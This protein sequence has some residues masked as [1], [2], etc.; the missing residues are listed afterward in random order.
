MDY[1]QFSELR[2]MDSEELY[3]HGIVG[4]KWGVRRY[5]NKDG[6]LTEAGKK[7]KAKLEKKLNKLEPK[8]VSKTEPAPKKPSVSDLSNEEL[9]TRTDRLTLEKNYMDA[10]YNR[11]A[12]ASKLNPP[13]ENKAKKLMAKVANKIVDDIILP[14][15]VALGK[16]YLNKYTKKH[17]GYT[18]PTQSNQEKKDKK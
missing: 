3:H 16:T 7:R 1:L 13:K 14:E 5:Q 8:A 11:A 4:M 10:E 2:H 17:F 9:K 18:L 6:T 15:A 12:S